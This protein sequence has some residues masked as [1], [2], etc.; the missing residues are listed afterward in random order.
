MPPAVSGPREDGGDAGDFAHRR[1]GPRL[2]R[3]SDRVLPEAGPAPRG[4]TDECLELLNGGTGVTWAQ[5]KVR[6]PNCFAET[7]WP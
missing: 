1:S 5:N 4:G 7:L 3:H 2:A 6:M